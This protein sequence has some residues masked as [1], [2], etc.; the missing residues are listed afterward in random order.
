LLTSTTWGQR[1]DRV[2]GN[3]VI[4]AVLPCE[5][6]DLGSRCSHRKVD[7][8]SARPPAVPDVDPIRRFSLPLAASIVARVDRDGDN[9]RPITKSRADATSNTG[10]ASRRVAHVSVAQLDRVC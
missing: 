1:R 7:R 6:R 9:A 5:P 8:V 10:R 3:R 4:D 2:G